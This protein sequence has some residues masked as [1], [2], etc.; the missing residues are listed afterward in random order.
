MPR[1]AKPRK[2][3]RGG[4]KPPFPKL[5]FRCPKPNCDWSYPRKSDLDRHDVN[6][7]SDEERTAR[8]IYC[9]I[10]GHG[11]LQQSNMKTH[12]RTHTREQ[13][14]ICPDC[15]YRTG[16]P[17]SL[18]QHR[19][20]Y[21]GY[22]PNSRR[23]TKPTKRAA[24]VS[25]APASSSSSS[26]SQSSSSA[27]TSAYQQ[28]DAEVSSWIPSPPAEYFPSP[29]PADY[30]LMPN[31]GLAPYPP[32]SYPTSAS[33]NAEGVNWTGD[34]VL[35]AACL[36]EMPIADVNGL[37]IHRL[38]HPKP[39]P[40][41]PATSVGIL[42]PAADAPLPE[43][44]SDADLYALLVE[45]AGLETPPASAPPTY[46]SPSPSTTSSSDWDFRSVAYPGTF[47]SA[48]EVDPRYIDFFSL[49]PIDAADWFNHKNSLSL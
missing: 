30:G 21:H 23:A 19:K 9:K 2:S 12:E 29:Y 46:S 13:P 5:R 47:E 41:Y 40:S 22:E 24:Q 36:L 11:T 45:A 20:K 34:A 35:D 3:R 15:P 37:D 42:Q 44:V 4:K 33:W 26:S 27:S 7:L 39:A 48:Q 1:A 10:C 28:S 31:A 43:P 6:H 17:A 16:D 25:S 49:E 18:T 14:E 32:T 38:T 8:M